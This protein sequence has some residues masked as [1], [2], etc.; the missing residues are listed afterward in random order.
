MNTTLKEAVD[1]RKFI[2]FLSVAESDSSSTACVG[3]LLKDGEVERCES[4]R[5]PAVYKWQSYN[6]LAP[7]CAKC[8][9]SDEGMFDTYDVIALD[10]EEVQQ[11][12]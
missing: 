12:M 6:I 9:K 1:S 4:C 2:I 3:R 11:W 10:K 7:L 8:S 5:K